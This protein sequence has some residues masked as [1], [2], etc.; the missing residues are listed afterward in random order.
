[1]RPRQASN[2]SGDSAPKRHESITH[3]WR[4]RTKHSLVFLK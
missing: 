3:G 4:L 1:M 2:R